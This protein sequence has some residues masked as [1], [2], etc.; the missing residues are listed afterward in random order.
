VG[1]ETGSNW[2]DWEKSGFR[3]PPPAR[4]GFRPLYLATSLALLVGL[5]AVFWL[6][7][8]GRLA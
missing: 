8:S 4:R 2:S 1:D 3:G 5:L 6:A 7:A